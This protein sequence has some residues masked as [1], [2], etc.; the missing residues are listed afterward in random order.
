MIFKVRIFL[1]L[2]SVCSCGNSQQDST[3]IRCFAFVNN[4][5]SQFG[6]QVD[7]DT[8]SLDS[9]ELDKYPV[10][11]ELKARKK[12]KSPIVVVNDV[13]KSIGRY[14]DK[15]EVIKWKPEEKDS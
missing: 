15:E 8:I 1:N 7:I 6:D 13:I 11:S 2:P 14:P 4:L 3:L 10:I 12:L 5:K 9:N